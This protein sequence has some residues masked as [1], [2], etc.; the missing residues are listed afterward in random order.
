MLEFIRN[1][2]GRLNSLG[3]DGQATNR[4]LVLVDISRRGASITVADRPS[5]TRELLGSAALGRVVL[6]VT[7]ATRS[8]GAED[9]KVRRTSVEIQVQGLSRS[10][11][12][13]GCQPLDVLIRRGGDDSA[14][15]ALVVRRSDSLDGLL[16]TL[17]E[18]DTVL[19]VDVGEGKRTVLDEL[20]VLDLLDGEVLVLSSRCAKGDGGKSQRGGEKSVERRHLDDRG[21]E[22]ERRIEKNVNEDDVLNLRRRDQNYTYILVFV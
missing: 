22:I 6:V 1:L 20:G 11:N 19:V 21:L 8:L 4:D 15:L 14:T 2:L 12:L 10:T 17:G 18:R 7:T 16:E 13:D 5:C 9:P 3:G